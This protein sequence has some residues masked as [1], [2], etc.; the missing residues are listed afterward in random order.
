MQSQSWLESQIF[1]AR[2][3]LIRCA[4]LVRRQAGARVGEKINLQTQ[5]VPLNGWRGIAGYLGRN[6][7]TV[8]RWAA[9]RDLPV[10]RPQ[11]SEARKGVPVYAFAEE[12]D[13]WI[14]GHA[15]EFLETTED[16]TE[17]GDEEREVD[18][19]P[20]RKGM[21]ARRQLV[22]GLLAAG[23]VATGGSLLGWRY[24]DDL[25][26]DGSTQLIDGEAR[27]LY[28]EATYL[29]QKRTSETLLQAEDLLKRALEI[30]PR[31]AAAQSD[32][33]IVY[34]LMVEYEAIS[35]DEGYR[36]S[37]ASANRAISIDPLN[38]RAYSVLGDIR[39]FWDRD[40]DGG[41]E[42]LAKAV[43]LDGKDATS[44]HWL[45]S[46]LMAKG[47]FQEASNEIRTARELEPLSRS[48]IVSQAMIALG[49][50]RP[51]IARQL[52]GQMAKNEPAYRSPYRFL[53]FAELAMANY[54]GYLAALE[55]RFTLTDDPAGLR[56]AAAGERGLA[57]GGGDGM[58][59]AMV[60][61]VRED[62]A[63]QKDSYFV[64]H[65]FALGNVWTEAAEQLKLT[66][67]RRFA[68]YGIDP[69]FA[70]ARQ[71]ADF[72]KKIADAGLPLIA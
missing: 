31:F 62:I 5:G 18:L 11:G 42:L 49:E 20:A 72:Q 15:A 36:L 33:A 45:A 4:N 56:V 63:A 6:Q 30:E 2:E 1:A 55:R 25:R 22:F 60:A 52:L 53:A 26:Q 67:T 9:T 64:G 66:P 69:A 50:K 61:A 32:L 41:L 54:P 10:H 24:A 44:R 27:E 57:K 13:S 65:W 8:K 46:A 58:A 59:H 14:R 39:F 12:L 35:V 43:Q 17:A 71:N 7:S 21:P 51:E 34:D 68:Y 23:L 16:Q 28:A 70:E 38:A 48:I 40:Y 29:W 19:K 3:F 37:R 47:R